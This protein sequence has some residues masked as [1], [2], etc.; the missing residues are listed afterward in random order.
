VAKGIQAE[1]KQ[2][3]PFSNLEE[4]AYVAILRTADQ[5]QLSVAEMLKSHGLSPTQ[6]NALRILRGAG[7][8]GLA[9]SEI[10]ER[11]INHDPDITRLLDRLEKRGLI[12]RSRGQKDRRVI[13]GNITGAGLEILQTL[14]RPLE[15][16]HRQLMSQVG[17]PKLKSLLKVLEMIR[18]E[19]RLKIDSA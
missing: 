6:F 10:G 12:Q 11:M 5:L 16:L 8:A 17:E 2:S 7:D 13:I 3:K 19:R 1:I 18:E 15:E 4:E 14:D 9:C